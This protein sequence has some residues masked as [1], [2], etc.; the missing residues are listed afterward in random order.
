MFETQAQKS[1]RASLVSLQQRGD[2][3]HL[4]L[5]A[6]EN[7]VEKRRLHIHAASM[8]GQCAQVF[9]QARS[10]KR[11]ARLQVIGREVEFRVQAKNLHY[12]M[13]VTPGSL[14]DVSYLICERNLDGVECVVGVFQALGY[15]NTGTDQRSF[16]PLEE[17]CHTFSG[18]AVQFADYCLGW[19]E[20]VLHRSTFAQEFRHHADAEVT[21]SNL[22]RP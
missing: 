16:N 5:V 19:M 3:F 13:T 17:T 12:F 1:E 9:W 4:L 2:A 15:P 22:A 6:Y 11:E 18:A 7:G 20:E 21:P 10:A 8:I 14:A